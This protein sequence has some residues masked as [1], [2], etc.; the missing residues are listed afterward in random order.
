MLKD[1]PGCIK[2]FEFIWAKN[3]F[4]SDN[5]KLEVVKSSPGTQAR[6]KNLKK[7]QETKKGNNL[8]GY[9]F[10]PSWLLVLSVWSYKLE[11]FTGL[12]RLPEFPRLC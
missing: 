9:S 11:V 4:Q 12:D 8:S 10:K 2:K 3:G 6:E 7:L 5:N 1:K